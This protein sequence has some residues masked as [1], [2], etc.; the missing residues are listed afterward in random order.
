MGFLRLSQLLAYNYHDAGGV[1]SCYPP[2]HSLDF[3]PVPHINLT[4]HGLCQ[5]A[6][7]LSWPSSMVIEQVLFTIDVG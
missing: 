3:Q 6:I 1:L 4:Q 5:K 2:L 7:N